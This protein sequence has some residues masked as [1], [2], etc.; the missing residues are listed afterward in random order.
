MREAK[1]THTYYE[2]LSNT[3]STPQ[4]SSEHMSYMQI[5]TLVQFINMFEVNTA[6][7]SF[8][9]FLNDL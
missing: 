9:L 5:S 7:N 8:S 6:S 2:S 1:Y 4:E 3:S